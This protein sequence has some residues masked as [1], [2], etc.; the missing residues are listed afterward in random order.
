[1]RSCAASAFLARAGSLVEWQGA[2]EGLAHRDV[3]HFADGDAGDFDFDPSLL[4]APA[5]V[6][7]DGLGDDCLWRN[8]QP[9]RLEASVPLMRH[10]RYSAYR[11]AT[12]PPAQD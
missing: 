12:K 5:A 10:A 9:L 11:I 1:M 2:G 6:D 4:T 3:G 8:R 7:G